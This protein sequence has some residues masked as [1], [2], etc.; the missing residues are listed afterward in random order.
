MPGNFRTRIHG[1]K[2]CQSSRYGLL[3]CS[4][5]AKRDLDD[6]RV[7]AHPTPRNPSFLSSC[8]G[9]WTNQW[10]HIIQGWGFSKFSPVINKLISSPQATTAHAF[11]YGRCPKLTVKV[12]WRK[13]KNWQIMYSSTSCIGGRMSRTSGNNLARHEISELQRPC[14]AQGKLHI[15][16]KG[17]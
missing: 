12:R 16:S 5:H 6:R 14:S 7:R 8:G 1:S 3:H 11:S 9:L 10:P 17:T 13:L 4:K 15:Q 2:D